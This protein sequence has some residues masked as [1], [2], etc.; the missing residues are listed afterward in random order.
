MDTIKNTANYVSDKAS[1]LTNKASAETNKEV[2]KDS[3]V[4]LGDRASAGK[5]YV[6]DKLSEVRFP[7]PLLSHSASSPSTLT[8]MASRT[9][10]RQVLG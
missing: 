8:D 5:D 6:G 9:G 10:F 4:G 1:E 7:F 2:A 3:N